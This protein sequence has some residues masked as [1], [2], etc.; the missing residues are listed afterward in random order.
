MSNDKRKY[1]DRREALIK[2]VAKRRRKVKAMSIEYKGG[3]CQTCGYKKY[4]GAL[5][6]HHR[7]PKDKSFGIGD[8]GYT[9]SWEKVKA[10]LDKCILL[11]ANC[12]REVGGGILQLPSE[13]LVE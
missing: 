8:K 3:Q 12:H 4:Q 9:R 1:S 10:E 13:S 2:A 11:C 6:L 5:E 7:N